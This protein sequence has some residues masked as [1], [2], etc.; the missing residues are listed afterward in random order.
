MSLVVFQRN[1]L[2]LK[3]LDKST[4]VCEFLNLDLTLKVGFESYRTFG[5]KK[6]LS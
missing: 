2:S 6:V 5:V 4:D 3:D 1:F